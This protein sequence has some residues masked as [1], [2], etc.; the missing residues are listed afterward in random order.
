MVALPFFASE[1]PAGVTRPAVTVSFGQGAGAESGF[2]GVVEALASAIGAGG[3]AWQEH[4]WSVRLRRS[5]APEVDL[6]EVWLANAARAPH[7]A[8]DDTGSI[9]M[10]L[11]AQTQVTV[12]SGAIDG[13][14]SR[15]D[16]RL[17]LTATNGGSRLSRSRINQSYESMKSAEIVEDLA[18]RLDLSVE[19]DGGGEALPRYVVDDRA[20]LYRH[21]TRLAAALGQVAF[22]D[23]E[24]TLKLVD[25]A[26]G[27]EVVQQFT[28]GEDLLDFALWQRSPH[29]GEVTVTGEGAAGDHGGSAWAW[30]RKEAGPNLVTAGSGA[31]QRFYQ[32]AT[33]RSPDAVAKRAAGS[34][35]RGQHLATRRS[36]LVPGSPDVAP[37]DLVEV[38][39]VPSDDANGAFLV[40][41][42]EHDY[43]TMRGFETRLT[44]SRAGDPSSL[45]GD[46]LGGLGGLP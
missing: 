39:G 40:L 4:L 31:P 5:L 18:A 16:G 30:L 35:L 23:G 15:S 25:P 27:G 9:A 24:G 2:G 13:I 42:V 6:A 34:L 33:L 28:Y 21:I 41:R 38:A 7:V 43:S 46:L 20:N 45:L 37:A 22:F 14:Q 8:L 32:D 36:L 26:A 3:D 19:A 11:D 44:V 1:G 29:T 12:F 17:H 10:G